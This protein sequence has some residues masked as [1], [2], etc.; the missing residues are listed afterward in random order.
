MEVNLANLIQVAL[1]TIALTG[2]ALSLGLP[3]LHAAAALMAMTAALMVFNLLEEAAGFR[4]VW[5]VTPAFRLLFPPLFYL[6]V[7]SLIFAGPALRPADMLH[8]LPFLAGLTLTGSQLDLVEHGARM[9]LLAYAGASA[10]LVHRFHK[11]LPE[12]RSDAARVRLNLLYAMI[13]VF[14]VNGGFDSL[15]IDGR[16]LHG[17]WPWLAS[18]EAYVVQLSISLAMAAALVGLAVR[19]ESLFEG[20]APGSLG[21]EAPPPE[22]LALQPPSQAIPAPDHTVFAR[23]ERV[24]R[25]EAL[26]SEPRLTRAEL[27][28]AVQLPDRQVS[29]AI[30]QATGRNFNDY[31]NALRLEDVCAMLEE[32]A[33]GQSNGSV[34]DIAYT[35]GFSSKSV[36]NA[37]FKR[38]TGQTPTHWLAARRSVLS[39]ASSAD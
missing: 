29:Q 39:G 25:E 28:T 34:L 11:A 37:V 23:I 8:G 3:R 27:A 13:T 4:E 24:L 2:L 9:S 26:Y 38:E 33:A 18:T 16:W 21:G 30:R 5:L 15:R 31:I 22:Q 17:D 19:R 35:A 1:A 20:L 10:W 32:A 14:V 6:L 36:F 7:R 12:R